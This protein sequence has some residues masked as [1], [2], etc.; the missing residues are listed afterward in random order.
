MNRIQRLKRLK[1][2]WLRMIN[3]AAEFIMS[4]TKWEDVD[5]AR[6]LMI[7]AIQIDWSSDY[8][9]LCQKYFN[10]D[11][12]LCPMRKMKQDCISPDSA[13]NKCEK[14][15][16]WEEFKYNAEKYMIPEIDKAIIFYSKKY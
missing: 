6:Y 14:S 12:V 10:N 1:I 2:N 7:K 16:S 9:P 8:D 4:K 5:K 15:K 13:W 11:C 3:Q